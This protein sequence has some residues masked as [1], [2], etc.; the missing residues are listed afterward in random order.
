MIESRYVLNQLGS[1]STIYHHL[2]YST[3]CH[4][5]PQRI[6]FIITIMSC[7]NF[8]AYICGGSF[9]GVPHLR[10]SLCLLSFG[11]LHVQFSHNSLAVFCLS[12]H[13]LDLSHAIF[14]H[15]YTMFFN[16]FISQSIVVL[17][18]L[19]CYTKLLFRHALT[20]KCF[21]FDSRIMHMTIGC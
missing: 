4:I 19:C 10:G 9:I 1:M 18:L 5:P 11:L 7:N 12:D 15:K 3:I 2:S 14:F 6:L 13:S 21:G 8:L 16:L 20:S 17:A